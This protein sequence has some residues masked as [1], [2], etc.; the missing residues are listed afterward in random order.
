[1]IEE[2]LKRSVEERLESLMRLQEFIEEL[3]RAG[4]AG[5]T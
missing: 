1:L 3:R 5:A 4:G 2:N